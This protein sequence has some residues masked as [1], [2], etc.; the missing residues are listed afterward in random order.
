[1]SVKSQDNEMGCLEMHLQ[2]RGI[3]L[4]I[5]D[6]QRQTRKDL[7]TIKVWLGIL[8]N[9][10]ELER[11]QEKERS[12]KARYDRRGTQVFTRLLQNRNEGETR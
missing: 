12:E 9:N 5:L 3:L 1:M 8:K 10:Q 6:R 4:E 2:D 7:E 11:L